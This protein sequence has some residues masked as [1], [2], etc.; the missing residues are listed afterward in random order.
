MRRSRRSRERGVRVINLSLSGPPNK[1]L[2]KAIAAA[3]ASDVVIVAA[4]GNKGPG[5]EPAYPAA[6]P[7]VVAVTAVDRDLR[8]YARATRGDYI[9]LSAP[10]V[11]VWTASVPG[12]RR[13][14][15]RH[16]LRRPLRLGG[17]GGAPCA[18]PRSSHRRRSNATLF[19]AARDL[20]GEG[21]DPVFGWGLVQAGGLCGLP[22]DQAAD[23]V[24]GRNRT[25]GSDCPLKRAAVPS[26][27]FVLGLFPK[28]CIVAFFRR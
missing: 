4:A 10:G 2:E 22:A 8:I 9:A 27:N 26:L 20:G 14:E 5:A 7:G 17:R 16:L 24:G 21:R 11:D 12:R 25:A 23:P 19:D 28:T 18:S 15:K 13:P 1:L 6:Y 3:I